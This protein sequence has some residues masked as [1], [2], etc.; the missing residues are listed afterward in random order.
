MFLVTGATGNVGAEL[1]RAPAES[2]ERGIYKSA[3][4]PTVDQVTG[5]APR[6]LAR[7]TRDHTD[8]FR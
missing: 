5:R 7:W 6:T 8:A 3:V 1:V 2:G 4:L